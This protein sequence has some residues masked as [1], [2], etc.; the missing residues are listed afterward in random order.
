MMP[1]QGLRNLI[2]KNKSDRFKCRVLE[3]KA[4]ELQ[5]S[6]H[7]SSRTIIAPPFFHMMIDI[8]FGFKGQTFKKS[9]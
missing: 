2:K 5:I 9:R 6:Q 8:A 1:I 4:I 3:R 7:P